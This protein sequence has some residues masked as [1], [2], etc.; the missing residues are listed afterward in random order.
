VRGHVLG[1]DA[2]CPDF[3]TIEN[4]VFSFLIF[5]YEY[6]AFLVFAK[7]YLYRC[8]DFITYFYETAEPV[9]FFRHPLH[10]SHWGSKRFIRSEVLTLTLDAA[11]ELFRCSGPVK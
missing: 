10:P 11:V 7:T 9:P 4:R 6:F 2:L 5:V 8:T 1:F 3:L